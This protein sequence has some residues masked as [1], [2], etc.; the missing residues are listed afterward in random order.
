MRPSGRNR[1]GRTFHVVVALALASSVT[2]PAVAATF[3]QPVATTAPCPALDIKLNRWT[4]I[5]MPNGIDLR[6]VAGFAQRPC[7]FVGVTEQGAIYRTADAGRWT[8]VTALEGVSAVR[9]VVTEE[10]GPGT[11]FVMASP[12][13]PV[14]APGETPTTSSAGGLFV[15]RDYGMTF[16]PVQDFRGRGVTALAAAPNDPQTLY[17]SSVLSSTPSA[18]LMYKSTDFGRSWA[19]LPGSLPVGATRIAVDARSAGI[20]WANGGEGPTAGVWLSADGGATFIQA[21]PD[22]ALDLDAAPIAGGGDRVDIATPQ[23]LIRTRD[24]GNTFRVVGPRRPITALTHETFAPAAIMAIVAAIPSR[25]AFGGAMFK[26][27][28]AG[29][30]PMNGCDVTDLTRDAEFPSYFLLSVTGC[31][32]AG[33]YLYRSD[34]RDLMNVTD[35]GGEGVG[36]PVPVGR[37]LPR[38]TM[39]VLREISLPVPGDGSS[40]SIAFDGRWLYYTNNDKPNIIIEMDTRGRLVDTIGLP[41]GTQITTLTYDPIREVLWAVVNEAKGQFDAALPGVYRIDPEDGSF[42]RAFTSPLDAETSLSIDPTLGFFRSFRHHAYEVYKINLRGAIVGRCSVPGDPVDPNLSTSP[43]RGHPES[44]A[45]GIA[46]GVATGDG[47]MYLQMED[48]RTIFNV[49]GDC[50]ILNVM[51]HRTFAE[52]TRGNSGLE[53]DQMACD[54]VTFGTPAIWIRDSAPRTVVAYAVPDGYC[55]IQSRI[56]LT[57][58]SLVTNAGEKIDVCAAL[59]G[60]TRRA[61]IPVAGAEIVFYGATQPIGRTVTDRAGRGCV[62]FTPDKKQAGSLPMRVKF[63]GNVSFRPSSGA[64]S[65]EVVVTPPTKEPPVLRRIPTAPLRAIPFVPPLPPPAHFPPEAPVQAPGPQSQPQSQPNQQPQ[66]QAQGA[67]ATQE[68]EEPQFAFVHA[69]RSDTGEQ[70]AMSSVRKGRPDAASSLVLLGASMVAAAFSAASLALA[71]A[72][73]AVRRVR[74]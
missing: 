39:Q 23:G 36:G 41:F 25:S 31:S 17:A 45:P 71:R 2:L 56:G 62:P 3:S 66:A 35:I 20:V 51:E 37:P 30:P 5:P 43:D 34:G 6:Y 59:A 68:Q 40:G 33:H 67:V 52:S 7:A 27:I 13:A 22:V 8:P 69:A 4:R 12:R 47:N 70:Y 61:R 60:V 73:V 14:V 46:S 11:A 50:E 18:A 55:P 24:D 65:L 10:L 64:G 28:T 32:S 72:S 29:L 21:R 15:T 48:D 58:R 57:P 44:T 74:R 19:P 54:T 42:R 53:N 26:N 16:E 1:V 38:T 63:F 49:S 9:G